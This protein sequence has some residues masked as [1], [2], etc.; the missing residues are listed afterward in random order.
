MYSSAAPTAK[1]T[2]SYSRLVQRN[3]ESN[4]NLSLAWT[5]RSASK[6]FSLLRQLQWIGIT[7]SQLQ[8][9]DLDKKPLID[10]FAAA[11]EA[12]VVDN[13]L[14]EPKQDGDD[15]AA[16]SSGEVVDAEKAVKDFKGP[17]NDRQRAVVGAF[18]HAWKGYKEFA[19]GHDNLRPISMG[20]SDWFGLG[21]TI[22]DSLDTMII[23][24]LQEGEYSHM[25]LIEEIH[26]QWI[27][28]FV[29]LFLCRIWRGKKL[30]WTVFTIRC[31]SRC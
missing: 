11:V 9:I 20:S 2:R 18:K 21:L 3:F 15:D 14:E 24:D 10:E 5:T 1:S 30:G 13:I 6:S 29:F 25:W 23:M 31:R 27:F 8:D 17:Q 7:Y 4:I 16:K 22:V 19:W 28:V 12:Q 26:G